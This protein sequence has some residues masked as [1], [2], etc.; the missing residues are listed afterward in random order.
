MVLFVFA[1]HGKARKKSQSLHLVIL[2]NSEVQ[3][4]TWR[5]DGIFA[6][7]VKY[8]KVWLILISVVLSE[9]LRKNGLVLRIK[10]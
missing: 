7:M 5:F 2:L 9:H 6:N 10:Q 3:D 4:L 8:K 1:V